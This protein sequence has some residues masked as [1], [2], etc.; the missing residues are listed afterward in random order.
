VT[1]LD[2]SACLHLCKQQCAVLGGYNT[3]ICLQFKQVRLTPKALLQRCLHYSMETS[4]GGEE[5]A[6]VC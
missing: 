6:L 5:A 1:H 2:H 3:Q 4:R